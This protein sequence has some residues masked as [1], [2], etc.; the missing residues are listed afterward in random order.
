[1]GIYRNNWYLVKKKGEKAEKNPPSPRLRRTKGG[2]FLPRITRSRD[3]RVAARKGSRMRAPQDTTRDW[4]SREG[5]DRRSRS[6]GP[7]RLEAASQRAGTR[8][9][10]L[11]E[12]EGSMYEI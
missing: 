12:S 1:M 10:N 8:R 6:E 3:A 2:E 5:I 9:S 7:S 11:H 4:E